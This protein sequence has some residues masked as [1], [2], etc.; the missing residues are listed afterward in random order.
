MTGRRPDVTRVYENA[1]HFRA[2]IPDTITL[3]Q[4][5]RN[6]GYFVMRIGKDLSLRRAGTDRHQRTR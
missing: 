5:F 2:N 4:L 6:A 1:T 3:G